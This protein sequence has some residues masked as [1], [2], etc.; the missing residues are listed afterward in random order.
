LAQ[1]TLQIKIEEIRNN[2][3]VTK[4]LNK[5]ITDTGNEIKKLNLDLRAG[6]ISLD[7]YEKKAKGLNSTYK[8]LVS[9][10]QRLNN[11]LKQIAPATRNVSAGFQSIVTNS[12][13]IWN[14]IMAAGLAEIAKKLYEISLNSARFEVLSESFAKQFGGNVEIAEQKLEAFRKATA[15]TVDDANLIKLSNQASDLGIGL[16]EQTILF[17][18]AE[19]AADRYGT[20]VE[21]G[22]QKVINATQ[23]NAKG[24]K[25]LGISKAEYDKAL[26]ELGITQQD[27]LNKLSL[28]EQQQIRL[29]AIIKA[30]GVTYEQA[31]KKV[32]DAA[33][34]HESFF[35]F[36]GNL[37]TKFGGKIV[38]ALAAPI[39]AIY[40]IKTAWDDFASSLPKALSE[41]DKV[42]SGIASFADSLLGTQGAFD[43]FRNWMNGLRNDFLDLI[44]VINNADITA[45]VKSIDDA[46]QGATLEELKN[47]KKEMESGKWSQ[48]WDNMLPTEKVNAL[49]KLA[50]IN[51]RILDLTPK[52][53]ENEAESSDKSKIDKS[54]SNSQKEKK[55]DLNKE[56]EILKQIEDIQKKLAIETLPQQ[57]KIYEKQIDDLK[58]QLRLLRLIN[59]EGRNAFSKLNPA[60]KNNRADRGTGIE[61]N[62][63]ILKDF[64]RGATEEQKLNPE[65][66]A[67]N[68]LGLGNQIVSVFN[69]GA[70]TFAAKLIN[71]L[72]QGLSLANSLASLI[73][74][75]AGIGSGGIFGLIGGLFAGGGYTGDGGKWQP[76]G[77]VHRGEYVFPQEAVNRLGIPFLNALSYST[78]NLGFLEKSYV[79]GGYAG[80]TMSMANQTPVNVEIQPIPDVRFHIR[81]S[82]QAKKFKNA[83]TVK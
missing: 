19:D 66:L 10:K 11:E 49:N 73:S 33:D 13:N 60:D 75:F 76:A 72:Q 51:E 54:S 28:E 62:K 26:K 34:K 42:T 31:T 32:K 9:E 67:N 39:T 5:Q 25:M 80:S 77:I 29:Q 2:A 81:M 48:V 1:T 37:A 69:L 56:Q 82:K 15:G 68:I 83:K 52:A 65:E 24:L 3:N 6:A 79:Y 70:D 41:F 20:G 22:F 55:E 14:G 30:S 7:D 4:E 61:Q 59:A 63:P 53:K 23:G 46:I 12:Q 47:F 57:K 18:L 17:S 71:G 44:G 78:G 45:P 38:E 74:T 8:G 40:K 35:T 27:E 36:V 58:E 43:S 21:E 16:T 64:A 50:T